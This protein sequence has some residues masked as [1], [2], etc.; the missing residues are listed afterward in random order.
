MDSL[1]AIKCNNLNLRAFFEEN[2][3]DLAKQLEDYSSKIDSTH[4][5]FLSDIYFDRYSPKKKIVDLKIFKSISQL[6]NFAYNFKKGEDNGIS[7]EVVFKEIEGIILGLATPKDIISFQEYKK[8]RENSFDD[9]SLHYIHRYAEIYYNFIKN[10]NDYIDRNIVAQRII[11]DKSLENIYDCAI[12]DEVQDFTQK[13]LMAY[14]HIANG[15]FSVGDP[16]QMVNPSYF[17]FAKLKQLYAEKHSNY[18]LDLNYR[19]TK[20][21]NKIINSLLDINKEILGNH[22]N[23]LK[24]AKTVDIQESTYLFYTMHKEIF[25]KLNESEFNDYSIVVGTEEEKDNFLNL[26]REV[27]TISEIKGLERGTIVLYNI[28]SSHI[29]EW[30]GLESNVVKKKLADENSLLRYYFNV[31]YVGITRAQRHLLVIEQENVKLFDNF[32]GDNF[33]YLD[34][35]ASIDEL[36]L[37]L[38]LR[39]LTDEERVDRITEALKNRMID[40]AM[41]YTRWIK[42]KELRERQQKRCELYKE[43]FDKNDTVD[44]VEKFL[45]ENRIEESIEIFKTSGELK[46]ADRINN[47]FNELL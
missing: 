36:K 16:L 8:E 1:N 30:R 20:P 35:F 37:K 41:H 38:D 29:N 14:K 43:F 4:F 42:N 28:L 5:K 19:N 25:D 15:I 31:F 39:I 47:I 10:S 3:Y 7:S 18:D 9:K 11:D 45:K 17:S 12:L 24:N 27:L 2:V 40:N 6:N 34:K 21:L 13:E 32:F 33:D 26:G 23:I 46:I 44:V 22:S